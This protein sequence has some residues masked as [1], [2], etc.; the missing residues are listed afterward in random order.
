MEKWYDEEED[1]LNI[2]LNKNEYWKSIDGLTIIDIDKKG[3]IK[4]IEILKASKI[5]SGSR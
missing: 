4:G 5:F 1:I 3:N 2:Q